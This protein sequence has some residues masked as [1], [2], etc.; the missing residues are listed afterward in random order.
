MRNLTSYKKA[1][2][3][4]G[5]VQFVRVMEET[6]IGGEW[7]PHFHVTWMFKKGASSAQIKRFLSLVSSL[8][9]TIQNNSPRA[10]PSS[11]PLYTS[12]LTPESS[13]T[14]SRYFF[15][16][17]YIKLDKRGEVVE[18][19]KA[20]RPIDYLVRFWKYGQVEDLSVWLDYEFSSTGA[21]RAVFSSGWPILERRKASD[22]R[23]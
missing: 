4:L 1:I 6:Q 7:T 18:E 12:R 10:V 20:L 2:R 23:R 5:D 8:W 19:I 22:F 9:L 13:G 21:R 3:D 16:Q 14:L 11:K 15:K 17:F